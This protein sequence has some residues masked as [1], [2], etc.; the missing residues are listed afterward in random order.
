MATTRE[1][2]RAKGKGKRRSVELPRGRFRFSQ[3]PERLGL[4]AF[5]FTL[6]RDARKLPSM[7]L[8]VTAASWVESDRVTEMEVTLQMPEGRGGGAAGAAFVAERDVVRCEVSA[9]GTGRR[10]EGLW[11]GVV[12]APIP[13][14]LGEGSYAVSLKP[15]T[16][17]ASK[18]RV[19]WKFRKGKAHPK[20]WTADKITRR[21]AKRFRVP[22]GTLP[23]AE[24]PIGKLVEKKAS[25]PTVVERAWKEERE[26]T[27]RRFVIE[28]G[29]KLNVRELRQ[30]DYMRVLG[31]AI[32]AATIDRTLKGV[33]SAAIVVGSRKVDGKRKRYRVKVVDAARQKRYGYLVRTVTKSGLSPARARRYGR[34]KIARAWRAVDTVTFTHPGIPW[35]RRGDATRI[36]LPE[37]GISQ[38][39][40]VRS[41]QHSLGADGYDMEVE[42]GYADPWEDARKARAKKKRE[43]ARRQRKRAGAGKADRVKS[44]KAG[45]RS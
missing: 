13:H 25:L 43:A 3:E 38:L 42:V 40:F 36:E 34:E 41:V 45:R 15:Q 37:D 31:P 5:R 44:K 19:A 10:W 21:A 35:L 32:I 1:K 23:E 8:L 30:P 14:T 39:A 26:A 20:G 2:A 4:E 29:A 27:G 28:W 22:I 17:P 33:Y 18:Q 6:L 12:Q 16:G 24:H 9:D 7:P 11:D